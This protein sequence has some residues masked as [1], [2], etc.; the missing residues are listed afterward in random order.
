MPVDAPKPFG[1]LPTPRQLAWHKRGMYA[2]VH[3]T[4][5]T[6]TDKEWG[7]GDESPALFNPSGFDADSIV[8]AAKDGGLTGLVLTAICRHGTVTTKTTAG[9]STWLIT[10]TSCVSS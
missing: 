4:I 2:F 8:R 7:Y 6:F 9:P 3:F 5:N 1:P 10:A